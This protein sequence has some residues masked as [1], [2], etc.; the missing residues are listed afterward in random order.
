MKY[1]ISF[2]VFLFLTFSVFAQRFEFP[3]VH[4]TIPSIQ[5]AFLALLHNMSHLSERSVMVDHIK[6]ED[7]NRRY[8]EY[9][10]FILNNMRFENIRNYLSI[11]SQN[12]ERI[13]YPSLSRRQQEDFERFLLTAH[14]DSWRFGIGRIEPINL[15]RIENNNINLERFNNQILQ[16]QN[17]I[18][19]YEM[20]LNSL[21]NLDDIQKT[22]DDAVRE[23]RELQSSTP[24]T[25]RAVQD[26]INRMSEL[27]NIEMNAR[28]QHRDVSAQRN[29][30]TSRIS[31]ARRNIQNI[32]FQ[33][34]Q[35]ITNSQTEAIQTYINNLR[36]NI[37]N[38]YQWKDFFDGKNN[39]IRD[40][41][42]VIDLREH[43]TR[44]IDDYI[45]QRQ[46]S[47]YQNSLTA[48]FNEWG[49]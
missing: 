26:R 18:T 17:N 40:Y 32:E 30:F 41:L 4:N 3:V 6:Y 31:S 27:N 15:P 42:L 33:R 16:E 37:N 11:I 28:R 21:P 14:I 45:P 35:V 49:I 47:T 2:F 20:Q 46:I 19:N 39:V 10:D 25:S 7:T 36:D 24:R 9:I 5:N 12:V 44:I 29:S 48:F 13:D 1:V 22:I 8:I 43:L 38:F 23:Y 34:E